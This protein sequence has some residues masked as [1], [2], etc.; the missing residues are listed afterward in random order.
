MNLLKETLEAIAESGHTPD[1]IIFIGSLK[2]GH[3]CAW[4]VFCILANQNY[5]DAAGGDLG[6]FGS[7]DRIQ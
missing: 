1:D 2:S 6:A 4:N 3:S 5:Y 7:G